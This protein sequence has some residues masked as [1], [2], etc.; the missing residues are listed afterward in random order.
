MSTGCDQDAPYA[1]IYISDYVS[2]VLHVP[3]RVREY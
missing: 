1:R 3:D 2:S